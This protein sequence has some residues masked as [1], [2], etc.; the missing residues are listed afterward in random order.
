M[1]HNSCINPPDADYDTQE[2]NWMVN[3]HLQ[4]SVDISDIN[5]RLDGIETQ[6]YT[7]IK[8]QEFM[9]RN[10]S[11]LTK[12]EKAKDQ[13]R[14]PAQ[15]KNLTKTNRPSSSDV[16]KLLHLPEALQR[17][18]IKFTEDVLFSSSNIRDDL[19]ATECLSEDECGVIASKSSSKDQA[20]LLIRKIKGRGPAVIRQFLEIVRKDHRHLTDAVDS[21]LEEIEKENQSKPKCVIC[22][23][24][25]SV[26]LKDIS[27]Y[28]WQSSII[29]DDLYEDI[30]DCENIH[31]NKPLLWRQ[32]TDAINHYENPVEAIDI[33]VKALQPK[34]QHIVKYLQEVPDRP[35]LNCLCCNS[36]RRRTRPR[37]PASNFGSQTDVSTTSARLPKT[38]YE[39]DDFPSLQSSLDFPS[40]SF[41]KLE[42]YESISETDRGLGEIQSSTISSTTHDSD[43]TSNDRQRH[44][45]GKFVP[46]VSR[47]NVDHGTDE[48]T[49]SLFSVDGEERPSSN[50]SEKPE[51]KHS[52]STQSNAT[53][54]G[55]QS[56][57][58]GDATEGNVSTD[59]TA[60]NTAF[61]STDTFTSP[62][63]NISDIKLRFPDKVE[64]DAQESTK[65]T[66]VDDP[67]KQT[68]FERQKAYRRRRHRSTN[69]AD[70]A[71]V[72]D[73][74]D[75]HS[76]FEARARHRRYQRKMFSR[77]KSIPGENI[78]LITESRSGSDQTSAKIGVRRQMSRKKKRSLRRELRRQG[79]QGAPENVSGVI[80]K[81]E[82]LI[83]TTE[84]KGLKKPFNPML[85][86]GYLHPK[87]VPKW[88]YNQAK[89]FFK[90]SQIPSQEG[91]VK[92]DTDMLFEDASDTLTYSDLTA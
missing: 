9:M 35:A 67:F 25:I 16:S 52:I 62:D 14:P 36:K 86:Q 20:R 37:P 49:D 74:D 13:K 26:D 31:R 66:D 57:G 3:K 10:L 76:T 39:S 63:A 64:M 91:I 2:L 60:T 85:G 51:Y 47:E 69:D 88:D 21:S 80:I 43:R 15:D 12:K 59:D 92:S 41:E 4:L 5:Q 90:M 71:D 84:N 48:R 40:H 72:E 87:L 70:D 53:I 46:Q 83:V 6:L 1:S 68:M 27:D 73:H 8:N 19:V 11:R 29:S 23:M 30:C 24:K 75:V 79:S 45:S 33:L 28:L 22:V 32:V 61:V 55:K 89:R 81:V 17:N 65:E 82:E 38:I 42:R 44:S 78:K 77:Q 56:P 18:I 58:S 50:A 7:V 54:C 34:Y